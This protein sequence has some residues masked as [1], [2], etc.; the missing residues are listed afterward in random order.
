MRESLEARGAPA[1]RVDFIKFVARGSRR[2]RDLEEEIGAPAVGVPLAVISNG[3][4]I[5]REDVRRALLAAHW[6]SLKVD[7]VDTAV[8]RRIDRP[9]GALRL[10]AIHEGMLQF[11]EAF[12]GFL[13]TETMLVRD[14]N[15]GAQSVGE[16]AR[17]LGRLRP[18]CAYVAVPT[19]PPALPWVRAADEDAV[20]RA[21]EMVSREVQRVEC[22]TGY[23]GDAFAHT[24]DAEEDILRITA[25]HP[26]R[27]SAVDAL[28]AGAGVDG[29]L[30]DRM[31]GEGRLSRTE[32]EG[33][34]F[35][36]AD[37]LRRPAA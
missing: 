21:F 22:L 15:D 20:V 35:L 32:H 26:M 10:E 11:R 24:G 1:S 28:L 23:E 12:A 29:S 3:A 4:L 17:F 14:L 30:V 37:V 9:H 2:R 27:Q 31:V 6:V 7:A 18:D 19:R 16:V 25:V 8:W 5:W 13:A 33:T 34:A 36:P